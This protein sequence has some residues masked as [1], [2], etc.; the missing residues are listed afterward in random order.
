MI[1]KKE[2]DQLYYINKE[3]DMWI[4]E[5]EDLRSQST[6]KGQAITGMPFNQGV[7]DRTADRAIKLANIEEMIIELKYKAE[8]AKAKILI[9][10]NSIDNSLDRMIVQYRA[11]CCLD[12]N[13]IANEVG[14]YN[15]EDSVKKRYYRMFQKM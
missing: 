4:K 2:V 8:C 9:F 7:S 5:L 15:T 13:T 6:V 10:I 14:G 3:I 1:T 11:V 12:W